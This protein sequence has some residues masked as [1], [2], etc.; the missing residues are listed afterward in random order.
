MID[1]L[2]QDLDAR[3]EDSALRERAARALMSDNRP[4]ESVALLVEGFIHLNAHEPGALPCLCKRCIVPEAATAAI[5]GT[6]YHRELV[7]AESESSGTRV[8]FFWIPESLLDQRRR[9]LR[10]VKASLATRFGPGQ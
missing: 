2:L 6:T 1:S 5:G 3:P 4:A 8:L 9:V 10:S 7:I